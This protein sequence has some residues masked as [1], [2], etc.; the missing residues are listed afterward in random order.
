MGSQWGQSSVQAIKENCSKFGYS[1][2][3]DIRVAVIHEDGPYG[4]STSRASLDLLNREGMNVVLDESYSVK[5]Q[6]LS[7]LIL[8]LKA[9]KPDAILH[10]GYFPDVVLFLQAG[11]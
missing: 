7:S 8:K 4:T 1:D 6:D 5:A 3:K 11:A 2:P 10:T 9:A